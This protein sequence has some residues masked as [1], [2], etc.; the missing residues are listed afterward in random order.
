M[1]FRNGSSQR[2]RP[3]ASGPHELP[4]LDC[5]PREYAEFDFLLKNFPSWHPCDIHS[6]LRYFYFLPKNNKG[7]VTLYFLGHGELIFHFDGTG[8]ITLDPASTCTTRTLEFVR[9]LR[10]LLDD[11]FTI[12]EANS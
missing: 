7:D 6:I 1:I 9:G 8:M 5:S 11:K 4:S 2:K 12:G 3:A 10:L